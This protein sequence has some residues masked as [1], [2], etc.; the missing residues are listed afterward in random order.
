[1]LRANQFL[2]TLAFSFVGSNRFLDT[3]QRLMGAFL[4]LRDGLAHQLSIGMTAVNNVCDSE[5]NQ[6]WFIIGWV[7]HEISMQASH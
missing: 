1:M 6:T 5:P 7:Y 2:P 3:V 4:L